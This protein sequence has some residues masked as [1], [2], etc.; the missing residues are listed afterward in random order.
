MKTNNNANSAAN[1]NAKINKSRNPSV[2][3]SGKVIV[4]GF[5]RNMRK[6]YLLIKARIVSH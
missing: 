5:L 4:P 6:F 1:L 2:T 3:Q